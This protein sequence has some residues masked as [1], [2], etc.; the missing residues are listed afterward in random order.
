MDPNSPQTPP[1]SDAAAMA[2]MIGQ[3]PGAGTAPA[4]GAPAPADPMAG[5]T[6]DNNPATPSIMD[7]PQPPL[8]PQAPAGIPQ[9]A[10]AAQPPLIPSAAPAP[11]PQAPQVPAPPLYPQAPIQPQYQQPAA[12]A[13]QAPQAPNPNFLPLA[14]AAPAPQA[15]AAPQGGFSQEQ[16]QGMIDAAVRAAAAGNAP[17]AP[18]TPEEWKPDGWGDVDK[19]IESRAQ[20][21]LTQAEQRREAERVTAEQEAA[22]QNARVEQ[23]IDAQINQLETTGYLPR[24][25]NQADPADP[26]RAARQEL[27]AYAISLGTDNLMSVAP[28]LYALHQNGYYFDRTTNALV[29]R[30]SQSAAAQAP[31]AGASP[32]LTAPGPAQVG[33]TMQDLATKDLATLAE[34]ASRAFPTA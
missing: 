24:V 14:P 1:V 8:I 16:V 31:I 30:G 9:A 28:N 33:P 22:T 3:I 25:A 26:G 10:P 11:A 13:P 34:E 6:F 4:P 19:R 20:E 7:G 32:T 23:Y 18:Q 29:R 15:P 27:Y 5:L 21:L 12:P 2:S 17:A